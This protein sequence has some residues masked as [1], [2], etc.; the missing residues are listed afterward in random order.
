MRR[1]DLLAL[2]VGLCLILGGC[3]ASRT[4]TWPPRPEWERLDPEMCHPQPFC[5]E[6]PARAE[7]PGRPVPCNPVPCS[8]RPSCLCGA[9]KCG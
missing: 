4:A 1:L 3:C 8:Q 5:E 7:W 9:G 6:C 2:V